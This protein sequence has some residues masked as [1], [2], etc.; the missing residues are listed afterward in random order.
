MPKLDD[1]VKA[2]DID[3][4]GFVDGEIKKAGTIPQEI[5]DAKFVYKPSKESDAK[6]EEIS[7]T[8]KTNQEEKT[9]EAQEIGTEWIAKEK[10]R[11]VKLLLS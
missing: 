4:I 2:Y 6:K 7:V 1:K 5:Y 11:L 8:K 9:K 3:V 10:I